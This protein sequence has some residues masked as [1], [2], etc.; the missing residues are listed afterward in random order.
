[1]TLYWNHNLLHPNQAIRGGFRRVDEEIGVHQRILSHLYRVD[2]LKKKGN[3]CFHSF[4][5]SFYPV[6]GATVHKP[7]N[8]LVLFCRIFCSSTVITVIHS[9]LKLKGVD[10]GTNSEHVCLDDNLQQVWVADDSHSFQPLCHLWLYLLYLVLGC[11]LLMSLGCN[12]WHDTSWPL[13]K[14]Q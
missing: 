12:A 3:K 5:F 11:Q 10:R 1:M 7:N 14:G 9:E 2:M 8:D 13:N 6:F 4:Q